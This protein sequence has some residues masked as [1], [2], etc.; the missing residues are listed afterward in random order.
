MCHPLPFGDDDAIQECIDAGD[1]LLDALNEVVEDNN[2]E[3]TDNLGKSLLLSPSLLTP[4]DILSAQNT[5]AWY[6]RPAAP[7]SVAVTTGVSIL[8]E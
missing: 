2:L 1:P 5:V 7:V 3:R 8:T 6:R 4:A